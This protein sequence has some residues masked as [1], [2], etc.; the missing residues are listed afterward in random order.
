MTPR[1]QVT[2]CES[3]L[4]FTKAAN[5]CE[6]T[7]I[8]FAHLD[9][10]ILSHSFM[11]KKTSKLHQ[12]ACGFPVHSPLWVMPE[13]FRGI[14]VWVP[15]R[16]IPRWILFFW[17]QSFVDLTAC[18]V[19]SC[20]E[21]KFLLIFNLLTVGRRFPHHRNLIFGVSR[22]PIYLDLSCHLGA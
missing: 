12:I 7:S 17:S 10:A 19:S 20:W 9:F 21:V 16:A 3:I 14:K 5:H 6:Y 22:Y 1:P 15:G 13:V 11:E 2:L 4:A 18:F 8:N